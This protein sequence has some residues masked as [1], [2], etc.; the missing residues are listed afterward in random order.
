M[1]ISIVGIGKVGAA[2]AYTLVVRSLGT[3]LLLV[4]RT[5]VTAEGHALDLL[6]A[7]SIAE[8]PMTI[9]AGTMA[10]SS[11]SDIVIVCAS[12]PMQPTY[13][14]R[15]DLA[16]DNA[17]LFEQLIPE[18]A[19][20]SPKAVML[21]VT[22]PV[23]VMTWHALQLSGFEPSHVLGTGTFI[24]SARYRSL[25][26]QELGI[27]PEDLRAYIL[28]EHGDSQFP[29]M[30]L[31][32]TGG[33]RLDR[34]DATIRL[35]R[36]AV[37]LGHA[38]M[39]Q[40]GYTDFAIAMAATLIV[41]AIVSDN[42]RTYPVSTLI[43]GYLGVRDVCLSLPAVI[44]RSGVTRQLQPALSAPERRAFV[45]CARIVREAIEDSRG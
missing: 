37:Q 38:A 33:E 26:S 31:A 11:G 45:K 21:I 17:R 27:H 39:R 36:E 8:R 3:E 19:R 35:F 22:N 20:R 40:K 34:S 24:D 5:R 13:H 1:K 42:R 23:D 9:R 41:E 44:G 7:S 14:T 4:N 6:H 43:N 2:L 12:A 16:S 15:L 32:V 25:L 10:E 18:L 28:G 30:S 29:A